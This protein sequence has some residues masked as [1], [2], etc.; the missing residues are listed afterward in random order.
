MPLDVHAELEGITARVPPDQRPA[1]YQAL[2][3]KLEQAKAQTSFVHL[4]Q[5]YAVLVHYVKARARQ[6]HDWH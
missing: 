1:A 6:D 3:R 5:R 2:V 4:K